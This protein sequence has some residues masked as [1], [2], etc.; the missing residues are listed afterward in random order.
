MFVSL[1]FS[2][3]VCIFLGFYDVARF[4]KSRRFNKVDLVIEGMGNHL[5]VAEGT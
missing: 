5:A 4:V 2:R 1:G 3:F